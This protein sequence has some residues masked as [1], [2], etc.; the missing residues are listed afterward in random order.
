MTTTVVDAAK[1][2][3]T[4]HVPRAGRHLSAPLDWM[5]VRLDPG[6]VMRSSPTLE[7]IRRDDPKRAKAIERLWEQVEAYPENLRQFAIYDLIDRGVIGEASAERQVFREI[8]D[9][10]YG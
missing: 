9:R 8:S 6:A 4:V 7:A 1:G 5:S 3:R 2:C 10:E